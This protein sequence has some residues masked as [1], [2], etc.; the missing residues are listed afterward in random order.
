MC[1]GLVP[2]IDFGREIG[3]FEWWRE[4]ELNHL[5]SS[6]PFTCPIPSLGVSNKVHNHEKCQKNVENDL[7][8]Q[9][10]EDSMIWWFKSFPAPIQNGRFL[11]QSQFPGL[12]LC[13]LLACA[14]AG[15]WSYVQSASKARSQD[16]VKTCLTFMWQLVT[17]HW[18]MELS[19]KLF[20]KPQDRAIYALCR[21]GIN[22]VGGA[23]NR[24]MIVKKTTELNWREFF[25]V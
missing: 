11:G 15:P 22:F 5:K 6:S 19:Q 9:L 4:K 12:I 25:G 2:E 7:M 17:A 24:F 16:L 14:T 21:W 20:T 8:I 3:H 23:W 10:F 1:T 13:T 18:P